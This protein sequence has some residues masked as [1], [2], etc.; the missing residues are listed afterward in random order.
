MHM[1]IYLDMSYYGYSNMFVKM[2]ESVEGSVKVEV[3]NILVYI[4]MYMNINHY[5]ST[6]F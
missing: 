1:D 6:H 5:I 3:V 2:E 4:Y